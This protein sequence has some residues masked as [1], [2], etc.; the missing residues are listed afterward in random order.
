[1]D[2]TRGFLLRCNWKIQDSQLIANF[3]EVPRAGFAN[4]PLGGADSALCKAA[5]AVGV[6]ANLKRINL[7]GRCDHVL[8]LGVAYAVRFNFDF[9]ARANRLN[10]FAQRDGGA[11]RASSLE[12]WWVSLMEKL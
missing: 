4:D 6:V 12:T 8:A 2:L 1:M 9:D 7:A 10:D 11:G 5:A 3:A